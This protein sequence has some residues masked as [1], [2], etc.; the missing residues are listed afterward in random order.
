M[1]QSA[2]IE[3]KLDELLRLFTKLY[4]GEMVMANSVQA[5]QQAVTGVQNAVTAED[6]GIAAI[7]AA[8]QAAS[9]TGDNPAIDAVVTSLGALQT[10]IT[11]QTNA[12][13]TAVTPPVASGS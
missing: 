7:I 9:P 2:R 4:R 3:S 10:D 5:L 13:N 1:K 11:N 12:I 8:L 6:T